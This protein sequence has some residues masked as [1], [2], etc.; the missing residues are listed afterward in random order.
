MAIMGS[1]RHSD[2]VMVMMVTIDAGDAV[3]GDENKV[4]TIMAA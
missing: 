4:P 2:G 1:D 3:D